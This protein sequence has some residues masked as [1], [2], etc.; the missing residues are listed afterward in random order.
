[1][2]MLWEL[3]FNGLA[4]DG[5]DDYHA[6]VP[7]GDFNV[8]KHQRSSLHQNFYISIIYFKILMDRQKYKPY[9]KILMIDK[10]L[11]EELDYNQISEVNKK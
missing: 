6:S 7:S 9:C 2:K 11:I 10:S 5:T 3:E 1:M 8:R 4:T